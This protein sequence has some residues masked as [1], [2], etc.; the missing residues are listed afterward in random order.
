MTRQLDFTVDPGGKFTRFLLSHIETVKV[1]VP[2]TTMKNEVARVEGYFEVEYPVRT[3]FLETNNLEKIKYQK[4]NFEEIYTPFERDRVDKTSF[5]STPHKLSCW[6]KTELQ[7]A[8]DG[9]YNFRI[10]TCGAVKIFVNQTPEMIFAPFSRNH[11]SEKAITLPLRAGNNEVVVYF[12]DLAE[13][14]VNFYF[15]LLNDNAFQISGFINLE[16]PVSEYKEIEELL[17]QVN[18]TQDIFREQDILLNLGNVSRTRQYNLRIRV[19]PRLSLVEDGAQDGNITDFQIKDLNF[20]V[21]KECEQ[22]NV[23]SVDSIPTAG[24]TRLELGIQLSNGQWITRVLTCSIYNQEKFNKI[25]TGSSIDVRKKEA[26]EYFS[27]L[28]LEDINVAL[29]NAYL[30]RLSEVE[31]YEE[32]KSAFRLI[33]EKGDCADFIL[34]PLLAVYTKYQMNFPQKFH[35]QM[36]ELALNFR[37]WI[38]EPGNDVM[39]Y[40]SENHALLFHVSQYLA[41]NLYS[42]K[43][44]SVS[45]RGGNEQKAIGKQ[46]LKEW[47]TYFF[48]VGFSE[49][50][51]TTYFPIDFIG[52]FSLYIAAPDEEIKKLAKEALDYTFKLIA[53]NYHGGT[54]ASTYG[55]VYEHN[56][57]AMQLGEI[58]SVIDIAWKKGYFNNSLRASALFSLTDYEPPENLHELL[59][60]RNDQ[61]LHA[62]Y[63]QGDNHAYTYLYRNNF[64]SLAT[65]INYEPEQRGHQQHLINISLGNSTMLWINNPGE[66]EYS[67]GNRP[68][69]WA[70]NDCMPYVSQYKNIAFAHYKLVDTDYKFIHL[71][72]PFWDLDEIVERENWLF[73]RKNDSYVAL[74]FTN[75]FMIPTSGAIA[76]REVRVY[77]ENQY[78]MIKTS[79]RKEFQSFNNFIEALATNKISF[80]D[81]RLLYEDPEFGKFSFDDVLLHEN[82]PVMYENGYQ[83]NFDITKIKG[84]VQ[85]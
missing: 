60:M 40:F 22:L 56:L 54:M 8:E 17:T 63:Q 84:D 58:S 18:L 42:D 67:G 37:Y 9:V 53:I 4:K 21:P 31:L 45:N 77:G 83:I 28:N 20:T 7:V 78:L 66:A 23:G 27:T 70:G 2:N 64:Y 33:E 73:I 74:F 3:H 81:D 25:I 85:K 59:E 68:S 57:K 44:F 76:N 80:V 5:I 29:V 49:W 65:A 43:H 36:Q 47:F 50:N 26:L 34:A 11:Y 55:R 52:F 14:D 69:Y 79:S 30:N 32:Y 1:D 46:R 35:N 72:L 6:A 15:E 82:E 38:D 24:F 16:V 12:E 48:K 75:P 19:N 71:Y 62:E 39:W 41:G 13:R 51:S 61:V 10:R